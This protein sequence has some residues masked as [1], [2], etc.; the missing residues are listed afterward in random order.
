MYFLSKK[1]NNF[2]HTLA[3]KFWGIFNFQYCGFYTITIQ[4]I[5]Y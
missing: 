1:F 3:Q 5:I 4:Y 2:M